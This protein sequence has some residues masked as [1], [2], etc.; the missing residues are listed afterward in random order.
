MVA[1]GVRVGVAVCTAAILGDGCA[2]AQPGLKLLKRS[3]LYESIRGHDS[4]C[5]GGVDRFQGMCAS[6][7]FLFSST[8]VFISNIALLA[9]NRMS[10]EGFMIR[11]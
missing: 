4:C 11:S 8:Q 7:T 3:P 10:V 5:N 2:V 6:R 9:F 1:A